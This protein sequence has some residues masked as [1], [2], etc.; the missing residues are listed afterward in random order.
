MQIVQ[1]VEFPEPGYKQSKYV[2]RYEDDVEGL[3]EPD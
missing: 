2:A 1:D 3:D